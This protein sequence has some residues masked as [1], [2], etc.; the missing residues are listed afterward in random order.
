[1]FT[2]SLSPGTFAEAK[3][4]Y[5]QIQ[6]SGILQ[7]DGRV[8]ELKVKKTRG[9]T[10]S[11]SDA[12]GDLTFV[13]KDVDG[14]ILNQMSVKHAIVGLVDIDGPTGNPHVDGGKGLPMGATPFVLSMKYQKE[15]STL[16][17]SYDEKLIKTV[18]LENLK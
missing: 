11:R 4:K 7:K 5:E 2:L 17:I 10:S 8:T 14:K 16:E 13:I 18:N 1:M 3:G 9:P 15:M 12:H 6:V